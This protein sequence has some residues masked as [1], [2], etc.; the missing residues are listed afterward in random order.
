MGDELS[1]EGQHEADEEPYA[2]RPVERQSLASRGCG[3]IG[4]ALLIVIVVGLGLG[5][6]A[7]GDALEPLADRFVWAP[8][9]VV[10]EYFAAH[11]RDD[12]ERARRFLCQ[13]V[14]RP[15]DPLAALGR[16][17]GRPYVEDEFPYPR[18]GGHVAI[19]YRAE[20][21]GARAQALLQREEGGWRICA[22]E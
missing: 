8:H 5:A 7:L 11:D 15:L 18:S 12:M 17:G 19:Y 10:R 1:D 22:F 9:D 13:G 16:S 20:Q 14:S 2:D 21:H 3:Y 4:C 6:I